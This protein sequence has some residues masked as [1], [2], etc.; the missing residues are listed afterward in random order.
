M[1]NVTSSQPEGHTSQVLF[2]HA[3]AGVSYTFDEPNLVSAAGLAPMMALAQNAG[4]AEL[5]QDRVTVHRTGADKGANAGAKVSSIVAGMV[6]GADSIDDMDVLRHGGMKS[7]FDSVYAP[8]TLGSHLRAYTFGHVRQLDAVGTRFL[9]SLGSYA[10]LLPVAP[11]ATGAAAMTFVD[12]DDTVIEVHSAKKQGAGFGY[13]GSRGLNALLATASTAEASPVVVAQRLREGSAYSARGASRIVGDAL[14]ATAKIPGTCGPVVVR[15]DSAYYNAKVAKAAADGGAKL[16]VTVRMNKRVKTAIAGIQEDAWTKIQYKNSIYD[17]TTKTW[18][19][20]AEVAEVPFTAFTSKKK[21]L[22]VT[23][24]LIVRRVLEKNAKK[25]AAGQDTIFD[26]YRHHGFFTTIDAST[27]DTA[28][29]DRVHR[30]HA[31]IEQVNAELKAGPL[32]HMPSGVFQAN[33]A[34]LAITTMAHNLMRATAAVIGGTMARA[35]ALTLRR[36]IISIPARIAHRARKL[37][38][39][40]PTDWKWAAAFEELWAKALGPP[41][42]AAK[43]T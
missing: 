27:L 40:L 3:P 13:Q 20:E 34:W 37:I 36:R 31:V 18:I 33:A 29:A 6:A 11:S 1:S 22:Q 30:A 8:S 41:A 12:I 4:L 23:G 10:P 9:A 25:L 19:S 28:A 2:N 16:S 24:R 39:H 21:S 17:E 42:A 32:T 26:V 7:L 14:A 15:A 38:L 43:S 5:A 35:R